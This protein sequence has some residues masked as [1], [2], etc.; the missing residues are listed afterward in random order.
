MKFPHKDL[1]PAEAEISGWIFENSNVGLKR[2]LFISVGVD[3]EAVQFGEESFNC[4]LATDWIPFHGGSWLE[5]ANLKLNSPEI[6]SSFYMVSHDWCK[7]S[8]YELTHVEG[9]IFNLK[10]S[11]TVDFSGYYGGDE[12]PVMPIEFNTVA[13][14]KGFIINSDNIV[15]KQSGIEEAIS[16]AS[17]FIDVS[18][19]QSPTL[20]EGIFKFKP[21]VDGV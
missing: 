14:F 19:F 13:T 6:E 11:G 20:E 17:A 7:P 12:D 3:F 4:S 16:V 1:K 21:M 9:T 2:G 5:L 15:P 10:F 8:K 18:S